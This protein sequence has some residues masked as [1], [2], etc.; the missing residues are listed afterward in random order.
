MRTFNLFLPTLILLVGGAAFWRAT[1]YAPWKL[2]V[3]AL[4]L[5]SNPIGTPRKRLEKWC[6]KSKF[7][8]LERGK[9]FYSFA[10]WKKGLKNRGAQWFLSDDAVSVTARFDKDGKLS[11]IADLHPTRVLWF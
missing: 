1:Y 3:Q 5:K 11:E 4:V 6:D 10:V 2:E 8:E 7:P 9:D